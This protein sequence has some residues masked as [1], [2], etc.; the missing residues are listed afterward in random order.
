M[1][2]LS[3][4]LDAYL[5]ATN[6]CEGVFHPLEGFMAEADYRSVVNEMH[7]AAGVLWPLPI[8]LN[9]PKEHI[10]E[11]EKSERITLFFQNEAVGELFQDGLFEVDARAD[12][13]RVF[14][15]EDPTHPGVRR[16]LNRSRYRVG[17]RVVLSKSFRSEFPEWDLSPAQTKIFFARNGW[18]NIASFQTRN[19]PH[20]AHEYLQRVAM[21]ISDG[22][23]IQ[24]LIGWKKSGDFTPQA[25]IGAYDIMIREFYPGHAILT[26]LRTPM[27]Y[28]GPREAVFH[29]I[30][31]RNYG[32]T[33]FIVGRDHAG[34]GTYY[35]K[36][37]AQEMAKSLAKEIGIDILSLAGPRYCSR[38]ECISTERTCGHDQRSIIDISG[39]E[40]RM[41]LSSRTAPDTRLMRPEISSYLM[42]LSA[43]GQ[44]FCE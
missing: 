1:N 7:T 6:F 24:P 8:T 26:T 21:E 36:Y 40:M 17:G 28:A 29:A 20:R 43:M 30:V 9:V 25:I 11:I 3:I 13:T 15:T 4:D 10:S 37:E 14:G 19:P 42:N 22:I 32:C 18:H 27:R 5:E 41:F 33:A 16:E 31:R 38:C 44:L 34:V 35:G 39:T 12:A 23:L 2:M